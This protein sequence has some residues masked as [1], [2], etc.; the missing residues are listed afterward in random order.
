MGTIWALTEGEELNAN[1]VRFPTGR[2]VGEHVN[3]E[4][5]VLLVGISGSG[6]VTVDGEEHALS[7]G[8]LVLVPQGARRSV[9]SASEDFVY[10]GVHR[11][12]GALRIGRRRVEDSAG[13]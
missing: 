4:V 8:I 10:L 13:L 7:A 3:S 6:T 11:W 1:L 5:D 2:G 12:R 9:R